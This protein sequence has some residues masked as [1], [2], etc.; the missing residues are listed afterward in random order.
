MKLVIIDDNF[1]SRFVLKTIIKNDFE[2]IK[3]YSSDNGVEALGYILI[4]E[5][6]IIIIDSTLPSYSGVELVNFLNENLRKIEQFS[7]ISVIVLHDSSEVKNLNKKY[8]VFNKKDKQF[9]SKIYKHLQYNISVLKNRRPRH[10][11]LR[12][13][14]ANKIIVNSNKIDSVALELSKR[15]NLINFFYKIK[16]IYFITLNSFLLIF[17]R[18]TAKL[19]NDNNIKSNDQ[20]IYR[21]KTMPA[22]FVICILLL[23]SLLISVLFLSFVPTTS[24]NISAEEVTDDISNHNTAAVNYD[25]F[26]VRAPDTPEAGIRQF[27]TPAQFVIGQDDFQSNLHNKGKMSSSSLNNPRSSIVTDDNKFIVA[28]SSNHRV[29]VYNNVPTT[30]GASAYTVIGQSDFTSRNSNNGGLGA[31]TLNIPIDLAITNNGKLLISDYNNHRILIYNSIPTTNNQSADVVIGQPDMISNTAN[32][33]GIDA[34]TLYRPYSMKVTTDQKLIVADSSNNR[35]LIYNSIP[36]SNGISADVVI[37]QNAFNTRG[38]G[39]STTALNRPLGLNVTS[40]DKLLISDYNN[41]R[42]LIYNSIPTTN[43]AAADFVIGQPNF[44]SN[45]LNNGGISASTLYRPLGV[46]TTSDGKLFIADSANNRVLFFNNIPTTNFMAADVVIGQPD[47]TSSSSTASNLY[48]PSHIMIN[49]SKLYITDSSHHRI[50]IYNSIPSTSGVNPNL[51]VGQDSLNGIHA[52]KG[53]IDATTLASPEG[54]RITD[55]GRIFISDTTDNRR[56]L[57]YNSIP[58]SNGVGADIV[59]GQDNFLANE[60]I[61]T[62]SRFRPYGIAFTSTGKLIISDKLHHRVLIFNQIPTTNG[63]SADVVI[64]QPDFTSSESNNGGVSAKTLV[65]PDEIAVSPDDKLFIADQ[66]NNRILIYNT[67]PNT[68]FAAADVVIC[69]PDFTTRTASTTASGCRGPRGV[70]VTKEGKVIIGDMDNRRAL[71]FNQTP[72]NNGASADVVIG[73]S[74]FNTRTLHPPSHNTLNGPYGIKVA[75]T[76]QLFIP[77]MWN[78]RILIYNQ[79]PTQN[80]ASADAVLGQTDFTSNLPNQG[81]VPNA[82][83]FYRPI[84]IDINKDSYIIV[85]EENTNARALLFKGGPSHGMAGLT[86]R[87]QNEN[88]NLKLDAKNAKEMMISFNKDFSGASWIPFNTTH[89]INNPDKRNVYVKFRDFVNLESDPLTLDYIRPTGSI[90]IV[91]EATKEDVV[92]LKLNA[93][94]LHNEVTEMIVCLNENFNGC[95][96]EPYKTEK[97]FR[98]GD[99]EGI[100]K[101]YVQYY[102]E[103]G[104]VSESYNDSVIYDISGP[105]AK[106]IKITKQGE[107]KY[108]LNVLAEDAFTSVKDIS[109]STSLEGRK[110]ISYEEILNISIPEGVD[111]IYI[112][113]RDILDNES[114]VYTALLSN[115]IDVLQAIVIPT[116]ELANLVMQEEEDRE[117]EDNYDDEITVITPEPETET[118]QSSDNNNSNDEESSDEQQIFGISYTSFTT[119][120]IVT[121]VILL[122]I[123]IILFKRRSEDKKN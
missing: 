68:N 93:T 89:S 84:D 21:R 55:D 33:G 40:D 96:K 76:G 54:V 59:I 57:I 100:Q 29:L 81:G 87:D 22:F 47:F 111:S 92:N 65:Y 51:V 7:K 101:V 50:N 42:V 36:T 120:A 80:F 62:A 119:L 14:L 38:A 61:V 26:T 69:Q 105:V 115:D 16:Y 77:E 18:F 6:D 39:A 64:G 46:E 37:G 45:T 106:D 60:K 23:Q 20:H 75:S 113:F 107:T 27:N 56:L 25:E 63:V 102:D 19:Y 117:G 70:E 73:Q 58:Q 123:L 91:E 53:F 74:D 82:S 86:S 79:I 12:I 121:T 114:D 35:I 13:S 52:N 31:N 67:I 94:D 103:N 66:S 34:S 108:E 85:G 78:N 109:I 8:T 71:I 17:F 3:I 104:V 116:E 24:Q 99:K 122:P 11:N 4:T 110:W 28:D 2:D 90:D 72:T 83:T 9:T 112:R 30:N 32:H 1:F 44:T 97:E 43:G 48:T 10:S 88:I 49:Q 118:Q 98:L 15:L 5:P 41:H 95:E